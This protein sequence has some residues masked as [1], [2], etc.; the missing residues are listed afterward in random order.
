[1]AMMTDPPLAEILALLVADAVLDP[2]PGPAGRAALLAIAS[3][4]VSV[5]LVEPPG[6][7]AT[8]ARLARALHRLRV[9]TAA[10]AA[11]L[12]GLVAAPRPPAAPRRAPPPHRR[13][14]GA[15]VGRRSATGSCGGRGP[16]AALG[17]GASH[18]R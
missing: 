6:D 1:P 15:G 5:A 8:R 3:A 12:A 4:P 2:E 9:P 16:G 10:A 17:P 7:P 18:P 14:W 11:W 13:A